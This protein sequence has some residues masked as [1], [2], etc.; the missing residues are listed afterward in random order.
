MLKEYSLG[1]GDGDFKVSLPEERVINVVEGKQY[2]AIK[3]VPAAVKAALDNPIGT[4]PLNEV[5]VKGDK[6]AIIASDITRKWVRH[7][8]FLPT[9]INELNAAGIP[10][11]DITLVVGLGAH[12]Y[13]TDEEN[14]ATYGQEV[15]D[16]VTIVQSHA[17]KTE[18]YVFIGKTSRGHETWINKHVAN[19]DKVILTG[20]IV[21]HLMAGFGGGR[22]SIMPGV[23]GYASIQANH[24]LCL[25]DEVG[26]GVSPRSIS[27]KLEG[28]FMHEDMTEMAKLINPAFLVNA[29]F[30][31][32]GQIAR[33]V[34]G[35][36]YD[37]WLE[38]TKTV[39][40]IF[41]VPISGKAD[42]VIASAGG[43][44]KDINL[45]QG[46]KT[47]DNAFMAAKEDG[48]IIILLEC[49]DIMEPPDFSGWFNYESLYDRE[50]ALRKAFTVPGFIA[51]KCGAMARQIPQILVTLPQNKEFVEKA[52]FIAAASLDEAIAIAEEKLA[53]KDY[54][55]TVMP[56]AA[57][58]MPI[59][60]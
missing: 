24:S 16:R 15:V 28:N 21:Y 60:K 57:N 31:A 34:A 52:G 14:V 32:E 20:G 33:I 8:L 11:S 13:H 3:D 19:A 29:V 59:I 51:L 2:A 41:G 23:S 22:K 39:E 40:E 49:R 55:V 12:R 9:L 4:P 30:T 18:D 54:T 26:K 47:L 35:H 42:L 38:G 48:V 5:V 45:Y 50:V 25:H 1:F 53:R 56:H 44:P 10:D 6:V 17:P 27:G 36:W 58:T 7:D 37:A 46:S 43:F